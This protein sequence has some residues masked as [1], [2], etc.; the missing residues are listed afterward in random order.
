M[1]IRD[2]SSLHSF[3]MTIRVFSVDALLRNDNKGFLGLTALKWHKTKKR[4]GPA[5]KI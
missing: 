2:F 5:Q 3:E 4:G 1:T